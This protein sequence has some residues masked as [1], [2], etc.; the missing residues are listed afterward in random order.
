[1]ATSPQSLSTFSSL[2]FL[3]KANLDKESLFTNRSIIPLAKNTRANPLQSPVA[4][5]WLPTIF[6]VQ[7]SSRTFHHPANLPYSTML[8]PQP[9]SI[10]L[11]NSSSPYYPYRILHRVSGAIFLLNSANF[12]S[13]LP[14]TQ[15]HFP[16]APLSI[17]PP[18]LHSNRSLSAQR[19]SP[20]VSNSSDHPPSYSSRPKRHLHQQLLSDSA[21][22]L[23]PWQLELVLLLNTSWTTSPNRSSPRE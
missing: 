14:L 9:F 16:C 22:D 7:A 15:H 5:L 11:L 19:F 20:Q 18:S 10:H 1:M 12:P 6:L 23:D 13:S 17:T 4:N 2:Y 8:L 3:K 21:I